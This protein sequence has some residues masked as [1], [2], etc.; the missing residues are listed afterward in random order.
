MVTRLGTCALVLVGV[1]FTWMRQKIKV[2]EFSFGHVD[3]E[4]HVA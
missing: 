2:D 3:F 4:V 1:K